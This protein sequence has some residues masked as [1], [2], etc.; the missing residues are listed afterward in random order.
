MQREKMGIRC[1]VAKMQREKMGIRWQK[2]ILDKI[3]EEQANI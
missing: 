1:K 3:L 2:N